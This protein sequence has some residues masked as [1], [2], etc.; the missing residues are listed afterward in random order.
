MNEHP[1]VCRVI[2]ATFGD[3]EIVDPVYAGRTTTE[4]AGDALPAAP[5]PAPASTP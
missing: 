1:E 2:T 3:G 5:V 4:P